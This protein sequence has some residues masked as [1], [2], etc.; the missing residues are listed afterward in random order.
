MRDDVKPFGTRYSNTRGDV[1]HLESFYFGFIEDLRKVFIREL[2]YYFASSSRVP[3]DLRWVARP[4]STID[5]P[6]LYGE[7]DDA[8]SKI[9]ISGPYAEEEK[10][11]PSI[12]VNTIGMSLND[13]FLGQKMGNLYV[14]AGPDTEPDLSTAIVLAQPPTGLE[15]LQEVG[16][17]IGGKVTSNVTI[18]LASAAA[19]PRDLDILSDVFIRGMVYPIRK[20]IEARG[21]IFMPNTARI[22]EE[23]AEERTNTTK[24]FVRNFTTQ[25][26]SEWFDDYFFDAPTFDGQATLGGAFAV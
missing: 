13:L 26:Q 24:I 7:T 25:V 5:M 17:R 6:E 1:G 23:T 12:I 18:R 15:P 9:R 2:R 10:L 16:E 4:D 11:Y 3:D 19:G 22:S 8:N 21:H 20:R 14:Q